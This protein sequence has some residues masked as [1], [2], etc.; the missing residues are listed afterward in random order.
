MCCGCDDVLLMC[1]RPR[2]DVLT[3]AVQYHDDTAMHGCH[4]PQHV[5]DNVA[6]ITALIAFRPGASR[7]GNKTTR[8]RRRVTT[9]G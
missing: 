2:L 8:D 7:A 6:I 9:D 1:A 4:H 3:L 5:L